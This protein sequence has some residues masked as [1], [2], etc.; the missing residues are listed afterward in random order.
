MHQ[1]DKAA[2]DTDHRSVAQS[3]RDRCSVPQSIRTVRDGVHADASTARS[4]VLGA[5]QLLEAKVQP[6]Q[7]DV[8]RRA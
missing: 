6:R 4:L 3:W 7:R 1:H 2:R 8:M 5:D